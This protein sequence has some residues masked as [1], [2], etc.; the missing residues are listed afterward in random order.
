MGFTV[1]YRSTGPVDE[2]QAEQIRSA[3]DAA[4]HGRT[5]LSCEP[6]FLSD[7]TGGHLSGGSKPNFNPH[8][9]DVASA[10]AEG[11]PDGTITDVLDILCEVSK[12]FGVD[13]EFSHDH[14]AGPIGLIRNGIA[15]PKL[16]GQI[17]AFGELSSI[18][19]DFESELDAEWN[20]DGNDSNSDEDQDD[21]PPILRIWPRE[22]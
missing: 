1:Y 8:P 15:D 9:D 13:W 14:D 22:D 21:D 20:G 4:S 18:M 5:W 17:A 3:I 19:K 16:I 10:L 7:S 11:F 6:V 12:S 2:D